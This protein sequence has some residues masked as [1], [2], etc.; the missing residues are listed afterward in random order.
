MRRAVATAILG[1]S[2]GILAIDAGCS[3]FG[4]AGDASSSEAGAEGAAA[5]LD[6]S[7]E[8]GSG[9]AST[10][11][12][13]CADKAS[14]AICS[15]F[16]EPSS[17]GADRILAGGW[18]AIDPGNN[19]VIDELPGGGPGHGLHVKV[20]SLDAGAEDHE[21]L[22]VSLPKMPSEVVFAATLQMALNRVT[23]YTQ[24]LYIETPEDLRDLQVVVDMVGGELSLTETSE[25]SDGGSALYQ[26]QIGSLP[27]TRA[28]RVEVH[29]WFGTANEVSVLL[30]GKSVLDRTALLAMPSG[31]PVG[32]L[33]FTA[34][35]P[36]TVASAG[37]N[38][39]GV[40]LD[41]VTLQTK[42]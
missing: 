1:V 11:P 7:I 39:G 32:S 42:P 35:Y 14:Y 13:F 40:Y 33:E 6:S 21:A 19:L 41:D 27:A 26:A 5:D 25:V 37:K 34:G 16:E 20:P 24:L 30:D 8:A 18:D 22:R 38:G 15:D 2:L 36:Y 12:R 29:L 31:K 4:S 28:V 23:Q 3:S 9:D 17:A 10:P